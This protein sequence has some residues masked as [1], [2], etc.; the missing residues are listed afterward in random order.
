VLSARLPD[1]LSDITRLEEQQA[2]SEALSA[3]R[4][5]ETAVEVGEGDAEITATV[6]GHVAELQFVERIE[7]ARSMRDVDA[8]I[9]NFD[10]MVGVLAPGVARAGPLNGGPSNLEGIERAYN[11]AFAAFGVDVKNPSTAAASTRLRQAPGILQAVAAALDDWAAV[12]RDRSDPGARHLSELA[13]AIDDD[14]F[15]REIR[16]AILSQ[17]V[18]TLRRLAKETLKTPQ[19][20]A[21]LALLA[22]AQSTTDERALLLMHAQ[23]EYPADFW[24]NLHLG[25]NLIDSRPPQPD[26]GARF[27]QAA[28]A[29]RP[30]SCVRAHLGYV[31]V[32]LNRREEAEAVI[33][34]GLSLNP[35]DASSYWALGHLYHWRGQR[36]PA[37]AASRSAVAL[38]PGFSLAHVDMGLHLSMLGHFD[39]AIEACR[40]AL[41]IVPTSSWGNLWL[42]VALRG[43]K[44][45]R[46]S[47]AAF[48]MA[49]RFDPNNPVLAREIGSTIE[50]QNGLD[51]LIAY[52]RREMEL[53]PKDWRS[54]LYLGVALAR[55]GQV[56]EGLACLERSIALS[57]TD[58]G[59]LAMAYSDFGWLLT[60]KGRLD[61]AIVSFRKSI[62]IQPRYELRP[63]GLA[64]AHIGLGDALRRQAKLDMAI[65]AYRKS[66][67]INPKFVRGYHALIT[68]QQ[69]QGQSQ[70]AII[71]REKAT[72]LDPTHPYDRNEL[73][74]YFVAQ[75]PEELRKP[76]LGVKLARGAVELEPEKGA[77]W[78]TLGVAHYR[79]GDWNAAIAALQKSMELRKGGD[80]CDWF[81][82]AMAYW[83]TGDKEQAR[84]WHDRAIPWMEKNKVEDKELSAFRAEAAQLLGVEG[85]KK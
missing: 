9:S 10:E 62:E 72:A 55:K 76:A 22:I 57:P 80:S 27:L 48:E 42:G 63:N 24:I 52:W 50:A 46:E 51:G 13:L 2:W 39:A 28:L 21:T 68:T 31:L 78:N 36:Q 5:A 32:R 12:R 38:D 18:E 84:K 25:F 54:P 30:S 53:N 49:R 4:R 15:R 81:V 43:R 41:E 33:R 61:E 75:T 70:E 1:I 59:E 45:Y 60:D 79:A 44:E 47:L 29:L 26:H 6:R 74:W 16:Q 8:G 7:A 77:Y 17:N 19:P 66:I 11:E 34:K 23:I 85:R 3:A 35:R 65:A 83:Q 20:A 64:W 69:Q 71:W 37:L 56:D 14:P 40:I 67:E 82:L 73:A 58:P